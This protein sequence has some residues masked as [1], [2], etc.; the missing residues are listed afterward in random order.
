[1]SETVPR[2]A[3]VGVG[4]WG[5]NIARNFAE[6]GAL[7]AICD[8]NEETARAVCAETGASRRELGEVLD[9]PAIDGIAIA[10]SAPSHYAVAKAALEAGKHVFVEKPLV[11]EQAHADELIALAESGGQVL[12]VGHLLRYHPIFRKMVE[13]V[14]SGELGSL[15]YV[16]SDRQS[17]GKIRIEE[18]VLW[19]FAPHDISMV[20]ALV[21]AEPVAVTAAGS[22]FVNP[23]ISDIVT[24]HMEFEGQIAADIRVSWLHGQ[25]L[26]KLVAICERG[27]I[28]FCDSEPEWADKLSVQRF[29]IDTSGPVPLP[30]R[31]ETRLVEV[32]RDEPL[33][34]ECRHFLDCIAKGESPLTDGREGRAVLAVLQQASQALENGR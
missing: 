8:A 9:D 26:Q 21:G 16:Q 30:Q 24:M 20:L 14:R 27:S 18:D 17:L 32:E 33:K 10:T 6:L 11:L 3:A 12:M 25:K 5:R 29:E 22:A 13:I 34:C 28:V 19:S 2:I 15:R 7:D 1:M 31:G 23:G 4:Y